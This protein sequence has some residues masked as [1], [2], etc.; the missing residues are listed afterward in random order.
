MTPELDELRALINDAL[1][2]HLPTSSAI[3]Q[4][5]VDAM[6]YTTLGG[7]KRIRPMLVC[8]T[9]TGVGGALEDAL[10]PACAVE[11]IHAYSLIHDDLP[12]MDDD[13]LRHGLPSSHIKFGE[14]TAVLAGDALQA[15]AFETLARAPA[16]SD[17]QRLRAVQLLAAAAGPEGMV[18]GQ[19]YDL[20]SER[21]KLS[22]SQLQTL[23]AAKTGALITA[24]V[25]IGA[26]FGKPDLS[27]EKHVLISEFAARIGLAF[28]VIDDIL[29]VTATTEELGKPA[30][31]D[32][33]SGKSTFPSLIGVDAAR[34]MAEELLSE[35]LPMLDRVGVQHSLLR[36]LA[37]LIVKRA[38]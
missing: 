17:A 13:E 33:S 19:S 9:C 24:A 5:L 22:L 11:F 3:A 38:F 25:E 36:D 27:P 8:A 30:G 32:A 4:P 35:A 28:Q 16:G 6:R 2:H 23:H 1:D 12:S 31:S 29:D 21:K 10:A 15:L 18:G 7:G 14:A 26:L 20:E 37:E 34:G